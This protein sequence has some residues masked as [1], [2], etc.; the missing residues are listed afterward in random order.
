MFQEWNG[1]I[2][3]VVLVAVNESSRNSWGNGKIVYVEVEHKE[4]MPICNPQGVE[5]CSES[6]L[7]YIVR[8]KRLKIISGV[9]NIA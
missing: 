2:N 1:Q 3:L 9:V 4:Y 7:S 8:M 5:V 6:D